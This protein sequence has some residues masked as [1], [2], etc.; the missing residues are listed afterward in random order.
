MPNELL[1]ERELNDFLTLSYRSGVISRGLPAWRTPL[2]IAMHLLTLL[3]VK[4]IVFR[5]FDFRSRKSWLIFLITN[6]ATLS[7]QTLYSSGWINV[8]PSKYALYY[9]IC[10]VM[11]VVEFVVMFLLVDENSRNRTANYTIWGNV[12]GETANFAL[13][14]LLPL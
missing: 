3:A 1:S 9:L 12:A 7:I 14:T 5:L 2:L 6:L 8:N 11:V 4:T 13:F 10:F